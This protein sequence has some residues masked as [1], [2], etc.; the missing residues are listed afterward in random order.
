MNAIEPEHTRVKIRVKERIDRE[1]APA[2][3]GR[4]EL[5]LLIVMGACLG[6]GI[7]YLLAG[8]LLSYMKPIGFTP[9]TNASS[10]AV[11]TP[12]RVE[13]EFDLPSE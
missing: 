8:K 3:R 7:G 11:T 10:P 13:I 12:S 2:R 6:L 1:K 5:V 9:P 4:P